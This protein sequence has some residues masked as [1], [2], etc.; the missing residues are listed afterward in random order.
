M[1]QG[2]RVRSARLALKAQILAPGLALPKSWPHFRRLLKGE[3]RS[4]VG[5]RQMGS[6][7]KKK[8]FLSCPRDLCMERELGWGEPG[9]TN[10]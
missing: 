10:K 1:Q 7:I 3:F 5:D 6:Q 4:G 8:P 9:K 2:G